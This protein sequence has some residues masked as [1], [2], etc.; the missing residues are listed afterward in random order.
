[1]ERVLLTKYINKRKNENTKKSYL[2][3]FQRACFYDS[4]YKSYL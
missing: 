3:H 1:M 2:D 4:S